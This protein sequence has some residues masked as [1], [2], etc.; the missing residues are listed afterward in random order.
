MKIL[1]IRFSSIGDIV[2]TT[3]VIR[4]LK[5]QL[6]AEIHFAT[7]KAF[8]GMLSNNPYI[9]DIIA[10]DG[11]SWKPFIQDL[12]V[13]D[14]DHIIDLHKNIRSKR[15]AR[16]LGMKA[17][18]INKLTIHKEAL[19][20]FGVNN[21]PNSHFAHRALDTIS[22]LGVVDDKEGMDFFISEAF[23][24]P[25]NGDKF[26]TLAL[27]TAH[28]TKNIPLS[29]LQFMVD[30]CPL[31]MVLLGGPD[32]EALGESL[33]KK[34]V[35]NMA[36]KCS[37]EASANYVKHSQ[38][39]VSGDTGLLHIAAALKKPTISIWGATIPEFGVFPYYG[40]Y[41][42]PHYIHELDLPCRPCSKH[43]T[44]TC[45][46]KHFDCMNLQ[47][48]PAILEHMHSLSI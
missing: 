24:H 17:R 11:K 4:C 1:I 46:K 38:Y 26:C 31:P 3:P 35:I 36:G 8:A 43:G 32:E 19:I 37:I 27:A 39:L 34:H 28:E 44:S 21:L 29:T 10:L 45:P 16:A 41:A 6:G 15:I 7:K 2:M 30:N 20:R 22:D 12:K 33:V 47:D 18:K 14:Y 9:D 48:K 25:F 13:T 42:I 23:D 5:E 40:K